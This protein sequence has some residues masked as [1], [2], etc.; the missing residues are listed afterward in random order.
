MISMKT[1]PSHQA[2]TEL[3]SLAVRLA[4]DEL[5]GSDGLQHDAEASGDT[6]CFIVVILAD[7][8]TLYSNNAS[9]THFQTPTRLY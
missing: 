3:L 8:G 1:R 4:V 2:C 9:T 7:E 5:L 6:V